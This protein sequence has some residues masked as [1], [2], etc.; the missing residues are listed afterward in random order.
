MAGVQGGGRLSLSWGSGEDG[1]V[2]ELPKES[3]AKAHK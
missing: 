3:A 1:N 2:S